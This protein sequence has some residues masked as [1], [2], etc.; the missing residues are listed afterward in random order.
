MK[1]SHEKSLLTGPIQNTPRLTGPLKT[2]F[3]SVCRSNGA[4]MMNAY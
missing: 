3:F 2:S 1:S 4:M